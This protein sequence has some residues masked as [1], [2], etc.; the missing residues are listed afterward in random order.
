MSEP[1]ARAALE[2]DLGR[3]RD[4]PTP[5]PRAG[6]IRAIRDA[7]GMSTRQLAAIAGVSPGRISR[8]EASERDGTVTLATLEKVA[9]AL[10][11]RV[12]YVLVPDRPLED[13]VQQRARAKATEQVSGVA[14]TMALEDQRPSSDFLDRTI[15]DLAASL[16]DKR[17][18]W[19]D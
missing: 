9:R 10:G 12:E 4:E 14:H 5:R 2:R 16:V 6:W 13:V 8:I 11:C 15:A 7:I 3:H 17:G 19:A 18:L 1:R